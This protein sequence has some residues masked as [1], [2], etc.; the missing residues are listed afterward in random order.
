M[1]CKFSWASGPTR[2]RDEGDEEYGNASF[3][4]PVIPAIVTSTITYLAI[5]FNSTASSPF[6][7]VALPLLTSPSLILNA[8]VCHPAPTALHANPINQN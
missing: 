3:V 4:L 2:T 8:T 1:G 6:S 7:A 5:F